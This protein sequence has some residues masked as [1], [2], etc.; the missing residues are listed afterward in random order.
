LKERVSVQLDHIVIDRSV[1]GIVKKIESVKASE[2]IAKM[3]VVES[4]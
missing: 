1:V 2:E 4:E 3:L